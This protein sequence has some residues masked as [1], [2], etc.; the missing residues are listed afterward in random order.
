VLLQIKT[1]KKQ[2]SP[3]KSHKILTGK[4]IIFTK[5]ETQGIIKISYD[6][7]AEQPDTY[8]FNKAELENTEVKDA[9][10]YAYVVGDDK[11][12]SLEL[13]IDYTDAKGTETTRQIKL[14]RFRFSQDKKEG[15]LYGYCYL[16]GGGRDF[17][18][19]RIQ[20]CV[21]VE[22]GEIIVDIIKYLEEQYEFSSGGQLEKM[23]N[24]FTDEMNVLVY[25]GKLDGM[26]RKKE[27][28]IIAS[29]ALS[30][31]QTFRLSIE[32]IIEDMS[33]I[34]SLSKTQFARALGRLST[35][36]EQERKDLI[37]YAERILNTKKN[38]KPEEEDVIPYM[39]K[40]LLPKD[41]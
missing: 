38:K 4:N 6:T 29:Y 11:K 19:S 10:D 36:M 32:E 28:E 40:R 23:W 30:R 2:N 5:Q 18:V 8:D 34:T 7:D 39:V 15:L 20:R 24:D 35:K 1:R 31:N 22:T 37:D 14:K 9:Y 21:N 41:K 17:S 27:K 16:R 12:L 3:L 33:N 25:V 13:E 26:L